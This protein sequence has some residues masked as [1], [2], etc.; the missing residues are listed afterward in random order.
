MSKTLLKK[1]TIKRFRALNDVEIE[2]GTHVTVICGKNGTS[3]SSILGIAA[4]I[5][6]FETDYSKNEKLQFQ[7]ITG[8][9]FKSLPNEHF[10]FSDKFDVTGSMDV[11]V[12]LH[13][14]YSNK[15]A[16]ATLTLSTR[17]GAKPRPV[18][19]KN[20]SA[21]NENQSRNFT[22]PVIFLSLKRLQ[23]IASREYEVCDFDY[24][25]AHKQHFINL[26]NELLN[27]VSSSATGTGGSINSAV[28]HAT[29]Y[30]QD[31]VSAGEDNAGQIILALMS[32]RKL[33]DEYADYKGG[34]LL[35]D[36]ADAGLFPAAQTKLLEILERECNQLNL[37]VV[38]TSHSPTLIERTYELSQKYRQKFKTI[39]LSDTFGTVKAMTD[40]S[41][42][43]IYSDLL[44]KTVGVTA[45]VSLPKVNVYFEDGEGHDFFNALLIRHP[46]K[47]FLNQLD[48]VSLGCANYLQLVRRD[49]PEFSSRSIIVLDG[50]VPNTANFNSIVLLP[51]ALP[52]DQLIFEYLYNLPPNDEF[53]HNP[54][55]FTKPVFT[56]CSSQII[57]ALAIG[58][59][60]INLK[61]L[62]ETYRT[63]NNNDERK[64]TL[65]KVFKAFYKSTDFQQCLAQTKQQYNPW[66]RWVHENQPAYK[67][68]RETFVKQ[69]AK[70][71]LVVP[72]IDKSKLIFIE[73]RIQL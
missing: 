67:E 6:S 53:W 27:K 70:T 60:P 10:R 48:N 63:N 38:M 41:W 37:Q 1:L 45:R 20:T 31:S 69:L 3:K 66:K 72:G 39:Y 57:S 36:E 40:F 73:R 23:P 11:A 14:G 15:N 21:E 28:A 71:M 9:N 16:T 5:F 22:H 50:D 52:P 68:F 44:T 29:S 51:S 13:D 26:N 19:R 64:E 32:F 17:K 46:C 4:Q 43:N 18:L 59:H 24:L 2:F 61:S 65:R 56:Q 8:S 33:K 35:I 7:S 55:N 34:L 47:K 58:D 49:V 42:S 12:E 25:N 62:V 54:I 30:D